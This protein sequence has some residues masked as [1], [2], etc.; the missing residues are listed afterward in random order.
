MDRNFARALSL[1]LKCV[2][3]LAVRIALLRAIWRQSR[4]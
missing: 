3:D 4:K 2:V 1:V